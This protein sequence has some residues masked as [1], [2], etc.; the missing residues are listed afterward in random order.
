MRL[1]DFPWD[2]LA[3]HAE[4]AR[5]HPDGVVDLSIGT[6]VDPVPALIQKALASVADLPGYPATASGTSLIPLSL[7]HQMY[8]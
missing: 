1:P 6:P 2:S 3:A 4:R 5:S 7:L 8:P